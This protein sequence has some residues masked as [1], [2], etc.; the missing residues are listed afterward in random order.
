MYTYM[1]VT[2]VQFLS[3]SSSC[4]SF[5][6]LHLPLFLAEIEVSFCFGPLDRAYMHACPLGIRFIYTKEITINTFNFYTKWLH[7]RT[8]PHVTCAT[9]YI[10]RVTERNEFHWVHY[11]LDGPAHLD[12]TYTGTGI[13]YRSIYWSKIY[14]YRLRVPVPV[15]VFRGLFYTSWSDLI[16]G[17]IVPLVLRS[18][19]DLHA[20]LSWLFCM[21][22]HALIYN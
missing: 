4:L 8:L 18:N 22:C 20:D 21:I 3:P 5:G 6:P 15:Q 11:D 19:I 13:Y 7:L 12:P 10:G 16:P 17:T 2:Y 1:W 9:D 14:R